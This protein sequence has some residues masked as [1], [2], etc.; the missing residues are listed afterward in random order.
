MT[1][2]YLNLRTEEIHENLSHYVEIL[3]RSMESLIKELRK[4]QD[5]LYEAH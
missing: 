3:E 1:R 2:F 4:S 5:K